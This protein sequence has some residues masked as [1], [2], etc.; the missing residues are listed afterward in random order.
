MWSQ[1]F[2]DFEVLVIDDGST[3][4]TEAS[5][6]S[7]PANARVFHQPNL[8]PGA[9]RNVGIE[10]SRGEYVAFLD[11]DDAWF[12]WTLQ[13]YASVIEQH[14]QPALV[15]GVAVPLGN[16]GTVA[17]SAPGA[18]RTRVHSDL[19][20]ACSGEM[21][22]VGGSPGICVRTDTVRRVGGFSPLR[23]NGEDVDLWLRLGD[24]PGFVQIE[25]PPVYAQRKDDANISLDP[26]R[27]FA[28]ANYLVDQER[29]GA[30]PGGREFRRAR[31]RILAANARSMA[32]QGLRQRRVPQ[33]WA[34]Y[35]K[36]LRWQIELHKWRFVA[37]TPFLATLTFARSR[38]WAGRS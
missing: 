24:A 4:E 12:P 14:G 37:A 11:S 6:R 5:L 8:G 31:I 30:Y 16:A 29:A 3:D 17:G 20:R 22:P 9:A 36:T 38:T 19:L 13:T 23:M 18:I 2:R 15:S 7:L 32:L 27:G 21:P 1:S 10:N 35:R 25:N 34:L 28:G 26:D 33:A